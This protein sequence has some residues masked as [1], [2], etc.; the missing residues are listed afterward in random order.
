[1]RKFIIYFHFA[2]G[3]ILKKEKEFVYDENNLK[4]FPIST[5]R[6]M[7]FEIIMGE[8]GGCGGC[9]CTSWRQMPA[10]FKKNKGAVN[11]E[12]FKS[13]VEK[14]K[15]CGVLAYYKN[16]PIAWC[17]IAPRED[18]IK[19]NNSKVLKKID[20]N[21]VYSITCFFIIKKFRRMGVSVNL[22]KGVIK[23]CEKKGIKIIEGYPVHPYSK[24]I[25]SAFAWTGIYSAFMKAGFIIAAERSKSRPVLRY[26][27]TTV[28]NN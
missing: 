22:L 19:L 25:P 15:L 3:G 8:K 13:V 7:D 16:E 5:K 4:F 18:F 20:D 27:I 2:K 26:Y 1:M 11:K 28:K 17:A 24:N 12:L 21:P 9:W 14:N 23:I 10:E 6:W